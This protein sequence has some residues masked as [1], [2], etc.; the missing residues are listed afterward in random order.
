MMSKTEELLQQTLQ[1]NAELLKQQAEFIEEIKQLNEQVAYLTNKLYGRHSE[2]M[3]DS[4]QLSL[5]DDAFLNPEQTG[6]QS[7]QKIEE[8]KVQSVKRHRR[9]RNEIISKDLP[10]EETIVT[11]KEEQCD[12]GHQLTPIGKHFVR[13]VVH[14]I[15]GRLFVEKIYE[16]T[17]KCTECEKRDVCSHV[18]QGKAPQALIAHSIATPSLVATVLNQ[19]YVLG[20]PLYR[21]LKEWHSEGINFSETT[22]ANWVIKCAAIVKPLYELMH[23][24][25]LNEQ[26]LQ[27]D[28]TPYEVLREPNKLA[29]SKSYIWVMRSITRSKTPIVYYVYGDTRSGKF[30]QSIYQN[31]TGVL[32]CDGYSG[33]NALGNSITRIGCWAHVRR[34]FYEDANKIS[35]DFTETKPLA[36]LNKMF[37]YEKQ[38]Q[39]LSS[40][41]RLQH[42]KETLKPLIN[43]FWNWC[44]QTE[45]MPKSRLGK[46][47][48]YAQ[49][50]RVTLN[51]VLE[52]G[53]IDLS[54]N[55]SERNMKSYVIGR[56]NWLF[57]TSPKGAE[58]NAIWMTLIE[59][60]KANGLRP[61]EYIQHILEKIP[62]LPGFAKNEDLEAYLPWNW[63]SKKKIII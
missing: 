61:I 39:K 38:W 17:Y 9:T 34:K 11:C 45:T 12:E 35:G 24:K 8:N 48:T 13:Q 41:E 6:E 33:Y 60:A 31:F 16:K 57:S 46:A 28:E 40:K 59:S 3:V 29:R 22:V 23:Q 25:L 42:R 36:I 63:Q 30:A 44:D 27:G 62:Q 56:K 32:Q 20:T 7:E 1:Q 19:K 15:P 53:E 58:A 49:N 18:F 21:Q 54:N 2:K 52:F 50:Q 47:L 37:H 43:R 51:R 4:N 14:R 10:I 26:F 55:A 5:L